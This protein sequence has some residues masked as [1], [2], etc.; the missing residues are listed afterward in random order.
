ME[1]TSNII[2]DSSGLISLLIDSDQNHPKAAWIAE[3]LRDEPVTILVPSEVL[4]ETINI[5]G[6]KF[7]TSSP[8]NP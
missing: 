8:A 2:A 3:Q 5:L 1:T 6:K 4:A 7:G